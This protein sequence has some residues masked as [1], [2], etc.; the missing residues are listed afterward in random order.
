MA[1]NMLG[2]VSRLGVYIFLRCCRLL[3]D[4][5]FTMQESRDSPSLAVDPAPVSHSVPTKKR[6]LSI[7]ADECK[8]SFALLSS[9]PHFVC[10]IASSPSSSMRHIANDPLQL[11]QRYLGTSQD[12]LGGL[13]LDLYTRIVS[14]VDERG[15]ANMQ[16]YSR[17]YNS[18]VASLFTKRLDE[19]LRPFN[20]PVDRMRLLL[21]ESGAVISGSV[22]LLMLHPRRFDPANVNIYVQAA[23]A[24]NLVMAI[25]EN[26]EYRFTRSS[27]GGGL[28]L[29]SEDII[30]FH[31]MLNSDIDKAIIVS[32]LEKRDPFLHI[33]TFDTT[34]LMNFV[35]AHGIGCAYPR[36]TLRGQGL[37]QRHIGKYDWLLRYQRMKFEL[38]GC[39][40]DFKEPF[41]HLCTRDASCPRTA[42][43]V[44]D[45]HM[46]YFSFRPM[47]GQDI[48]PPVSAESLCYMLLL[49]RSHR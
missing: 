17:S 29:Y 22:A 1:L 38:A 9:Y 40:L 27:P 26:T 18:S 49:I 4:T 34:L 39:L 5:L 45:G 7:Q 12:L 48:V 23:E 37:S 24:T 13:P 6:K 3:C 41:E 43:H 20:V 11:I 36:M 10:S 31:Y 2:V 33:M 25:E 47:N 30:S 42:R 15:L 8:W 35:T 28:T 44:R 46:M 32:V 21:E 19:V 16:R 14:L